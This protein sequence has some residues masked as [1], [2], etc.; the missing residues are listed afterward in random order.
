[1][2]T[3]AEEGEAVSYTQLQVSS[4]MLAVKKHM[5]AAWVVSGDFEGQII[6]V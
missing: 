1:M 2:A 6:Q 4:P 5:A 3:F